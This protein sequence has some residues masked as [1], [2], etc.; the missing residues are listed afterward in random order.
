MLGAHIQTLRKPTGRLVLSALSGVFSPSF[1]HSPTACSLAFSPYR[2]RWPWHFHFLSCQLRSL[3]CCEWDNITRWRLLPL[4][5][6]A[7][8]VPFH[9]A[10]FPCCSIFWKTE[11]SRLL[12]KFL[13]VYSARGSPQKRMLF[14]FIFFQYR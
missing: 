5:P 11:S 2:M 8:Y 14:V 6:R 3:P 1:P 10:D 7:S 13:P 9:T 12:T 4:T